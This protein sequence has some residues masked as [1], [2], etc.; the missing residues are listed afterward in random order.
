MC[1]ENVSVCMASYNGALYIKE[2]I[3][4]ILPQLSR[5]DE[6]IIVDDRSTDN[7]KE[8]ISAIPDNRI[9]L[10]Q[11]TSNKGVVKSFEEAVRLAG[12]EYIFLADQ[13]DI[14]TKN[15]MEKMLHLIQR[16][17]VMLVTGNMVAIDKRGNR[18]KKTF[19]RLQAKD[20]CNYMLN[21]S[22]IF[23]GKASYYG[24]AMAFKRELKEVILP[25]PKYMESHDTWIAMAANL[26][27]SNVHL[28]YTV[29]EHRLHGNNV[30]KS[31]RKLGKR[32]HSRI[33]FARALGE[34][35]IRIIR[36]R[37]IQGGE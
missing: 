36:Y 35:S 15:R 33:L 22:R 32:L 10:Y 17:S 13:D 21:I 4:S 28:E 29:L 26:L 20:S 14:W 25:F 31:H 37:I 23:G 34:L 3:E 27:K 7:T 24:C 2:Q 12:N 9:K 18:S 19:E 5:E 11:N 6:L 1:K 8:I 16:Y 30:T